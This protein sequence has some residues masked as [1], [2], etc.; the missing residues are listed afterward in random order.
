[1][2]QRRADRLFDSGYTLGGAFQAVR[3]ASAE[4]T[5]L[6]EA[7]GGMQGLFR[8]LTTPRGLPLANWDKG[9]YD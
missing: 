8:D 2:T 1:M 7:V 5:V 9:A 6:Q 4:D 3:G